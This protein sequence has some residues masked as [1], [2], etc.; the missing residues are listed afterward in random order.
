MVC[1]WSLF[2]SFQNALPSAQMRVVCRAVPHVSSARAII[3]TVLH[4]ST[5]QSLVQSKLLRGLFPDAPLPS[6]LSAEGFVDRIQKGAATSII[7]ICIFSGPTRLTLSEVQHITAVGIRHNHLEVSFR[8]QFQK[9]ILTYH[10]RLR[11][12][13]KSIH[14]QR[15]LE[16]QDR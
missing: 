14:R 1:D 6:R 16:K 7:S 10:Y 8:L 12:G 4:P 2:S 11:L 5:L 3:P 9:N 13:R 15:S